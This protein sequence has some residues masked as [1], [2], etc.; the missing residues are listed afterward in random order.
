MKEVVKAGRKPGTVK[1]LADTDA[2]GESR[3]ETL[4]IEAVKKTARDCE[5]VAG[6][7]AGIEQLVLK[8][9]KFM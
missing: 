1:T 5:V 8:L 4:S 9:R 6:D 3:V 2:S 7:D